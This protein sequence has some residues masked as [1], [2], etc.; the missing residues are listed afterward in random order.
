MSARG[1]RVRLADVA[2]LAGVSTTTASR[3][4]NGR[5]EL[6]DDT[7]AAV[8]D[9]ANRLGFRPSPFAQSLRTRRSNTIGLI[10]PHVDHP[11]YAS[12]VQGAQSHLRDAGYRLI[13]MDSG[14]DSESVAKAIDTLLDHWVDG[15]MISTTP[16]TAG[17]FAELLHGTPCIFIDE[18]VEGVGAGAVTLENRRG[19]ELL[20]DHLAG[21]GH[22]T[23]AFLGGPADRT[24]GRERRE[25]FLAAMA[26]RG[27]NVEV[28][29]VRDGE[30]NLRS[31]ATETLALLDGGESPTALVAA[32]AEL[33]LGAIAAARSRGL[34]LPEDLALGSFD[35]PYFAPLLEPALTAVAYD[36]PGIGASSARLLVEAIESDVPEYRQV[37]VEVHL[38]LRR[39]CGCE[40]NIMSA[41][42]NVAPF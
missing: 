8:L 33:A 38:V 5:G 27:L 21:H 12:I 40:F 6:T 14:E 7:R 42:A 9:A 26:A 10:V 28:G 35:D 41:L 36:A 15:I 25:G 34:R 22:E 2:R 13:L 20:V 17:G 31:A 19:V 1:A 29:M 16:L 4:L 11:F 32:S 37:R 30:W 3:A 24:D 18:T 23:I 39:S